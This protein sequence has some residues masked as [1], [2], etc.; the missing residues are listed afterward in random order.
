MGIL[1]L[2]EKNKSL[3][4]AGDSLEKAVR[5]VKKGGVIAYPTDTVYGIGVSP[6]MNGWVQRISIVKNRPVD[7]PV[8]IAFHSLDTAL[9]YAELDEFFDILEKLFPG[10]Y[11]VIA[12]KKKNFKEYPW[13]KIGIRVPG[14]PVSLQL[15]S[16]AGPLS[17]TSANLHGH[18][19][20]SKWEDVSLKVDYILKG[21]CIYG[22][23][24]TVVDLTERTIIRSG[25]S[26]ERIR[27]EF[28]KKGLHLTVK[29]S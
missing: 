6:F 11:T 2:L 24:S 16:N 13:E 8:S 28:S 18:P 12:L 15:L 21:R 14:H 27:E 10:P 22:I 5:I 9:K 3:M 23:P 26:M 29:L 7:K 4:S 25:V 1:P 19:P 20:P 17:A